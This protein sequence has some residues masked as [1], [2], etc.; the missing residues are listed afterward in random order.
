MATVLRCFRG[1]RDRVGMNLG[2][3]PC[4]NWLN[5]QRIVVIM[6]VLDHGSKVADKHIPWSGRIVH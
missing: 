4:L 3:Y 6:Q 5:G 2:R 1:D